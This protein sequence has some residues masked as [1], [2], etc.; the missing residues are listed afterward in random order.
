MRKMTI[1]AA[2]ALVLFTTYD[3][4]AMT[5]GSLR[6]HIVRAA[7]EDHIDHAVQPAGLSWLI[8]IASITIERLKSIA[9]VRTPEPRKPETIDI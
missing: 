8:T 6:P 7:A 1:A 9:L 5:L 2:T 3:A 4:T